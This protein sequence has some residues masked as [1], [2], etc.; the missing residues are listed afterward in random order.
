M[1][2]QT[3]K[4]ENEDIIP[5]LIDQKPIRLNMALSCSLIV[6]RKLVIM[7]LGSQSSPGG[8]NADNFK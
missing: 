7:K 2:S 1:C 4:H 3:V 8:K 5:D 6:P